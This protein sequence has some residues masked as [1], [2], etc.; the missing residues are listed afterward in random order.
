M[1]IGVKLQ[2]FKEA[3]EN[4][5]I[6]GP[7]VEANVIGVAISTA[8]QPIVKRAKQL[9]AVRTGAL[10]ASITSVLKKYP[11]KAVVIIGPD[12]DYYEAGKRVKGKAGVRADRP[13]KYA[14][15]VEFGF[16]TRNAAANATS[17]K[18][19]AYTAKEK[20]AAAEAGRAL[21]SAG[22][23]AVSFVAARPFLRP[24]VLQGQAEAA[25]S[26]EKGVAKGLEREIKKLNVKI[27]K[28]RGQA[29]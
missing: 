23:R 7:R 2:G 11:G 19:I 27:I 25:I 13:S 6:L 8:A 10:K 5:R 9:A 14:H 22:R 20:K 28:Q 17:K 15:L 4:L 21:P 12:R 16:H 18:M 29:A 26:F 1:K 24:A 3:T